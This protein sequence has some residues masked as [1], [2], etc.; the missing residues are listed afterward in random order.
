MTRQVW[1]FDEAA[2]HDPLS[3]ETDP[4]PA[5]RVARD[6]V[7]RAYLAQGDAG[8]YTQLVRMPPGFEAPVHSHDHAEVFVVLEGSCTFDGV[9]MGARDLTVVA[10]DEPYGFVAGPEGLVFLVVRTGAAGFRAGGEQA[11]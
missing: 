3:P 8:F 4:A 1:K 11:R 10:A 6:G 7:A 9:P 5:A 2:W